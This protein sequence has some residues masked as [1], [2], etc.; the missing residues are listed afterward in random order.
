MLINKDT[1]GIIIQGP[2]DYHH[3]IVADFYSQFENVVWSTWADEPKNNIEYIKSTGIKV[4]TSNKPD[5]AGYLNVNL[6]YK[7][8]LKG[9]EYYKERGYTEVLK[10]RSD[11]IF[12]GIERVMHVLKGKDV[13]FMAMHNPQKL[14]FL[15]YYLDYY[16]HG[17]DFPC[18]YAV[19]GS[20]ESMYNMFN[21]NVSYNLPIPPESIMLR[22]Y[23]EYKKI[24]PIF[25]FN[26]LINNGI[27]FF[28]K[29][30]IENNASIHWL[31]KSPFYNMTYAMTDIEKD[32]YFY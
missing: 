9:I 30:C 12:F 28:T 4:I 6:Q 8:T 24:N 21:C 1:Q 23:L 31:K 25:D 20:I 14:T 18:D 22:N 7:T 32:C 10:V 2:T 17:M 15:A 26:H 13:S 19:F 27:H 16:H 29:D 5:Y 11:I 3:K